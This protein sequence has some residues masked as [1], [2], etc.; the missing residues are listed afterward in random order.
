MGAEDVPGYEWSSA[1]LIRPIGRYRPQL[2]IPRVAW[3]QAIRR[4]LTKDASPHHLQ[5]ALFCPFCPLYLNLVHIGP[6]FSK[7]GNKT[8]RTGIGSLSDRRN[9]HLKELPFTTLDKFVKYYGVSYT[10]TGTDFGCKYSG[11]QVASLVRGNIM[12][13]KGTPSPHQ[14]RCG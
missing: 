10:G 3:A 14:L 5:A 4:C 2:W 1:I 6:N 13:I 11:K 12:S 9:P 7:K 8:D